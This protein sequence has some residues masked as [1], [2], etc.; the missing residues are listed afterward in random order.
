MRGGNLKGSP[1]EKSQQII[2]DAFGVF[3]KH[4]RWF[5]ISQAHRVPV[6]AGTHTA[7]WPITKAFLSRQLNTTWNS[8]LTWT[9]KLLI[10]DTL[11][12]PS[13]VFSINLCLGWPGTASDLSRIL[14]PEEFNAFVMFL[15]A[16]ADWG[17]KETSGSDAATDFGVAA[18]TLPA[19][20]TSSTSASA[21]T[22]S[23]ASA[24]S[25][26]ALDFSSDLQGPLEWGQNSEI[27][28]VCG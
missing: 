28:L 1:R 26:A 17:W 5:R 7:N 9:S 18:P 15:N 16:M 22:P 20:V 6:A 21:S 11:T 27:Q 25:R 24:T 3:Y 2:I 8:I 19:S 23:S 14:R 12:L 4:C 10:P 13:N